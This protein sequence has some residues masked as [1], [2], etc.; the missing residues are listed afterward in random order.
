MRSMS[1]GFA[2]AVIESN[3][4]AHVSVSSLG[5]FEGE[6]FVCFAPVHIDSD[7]CV[8]DVSIGVTFE[9]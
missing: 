9:T 5:P 7:M 1:I 2:L 4:L 6:A 8:A 3:I